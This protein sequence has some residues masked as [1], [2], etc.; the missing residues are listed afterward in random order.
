MS[1]NP[2]A[3]PATPIK[4]SDVPPR[5]GSPMLA[6]LIGWAADIFGTTIFASIAIVVLGMLLGAGGASEP[7]LISIERSSGWQAFG[8]IFGMGF[9]ALGGYVTARIANHAEYKL[10]A[11]TGLCSLAT[12]EIFIQ[13]SDADNSMFWVRLVGFV[14]T[15]PA[16]L[17]GAWWYLQRTQTDD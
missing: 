4:S 16:A 14:F 12:G 5:R 15:L 9:T 10:A 8:L 13:M 11:I 6:V 3:P 2:Y 7:E 1:D 17:G